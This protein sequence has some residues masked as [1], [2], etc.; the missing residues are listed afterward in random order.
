M[1]SWHTIFDHYFCV[2]SKTLSEEQREKLFETINSATDLLGWKVEI[3]SPND[4][5]NAM[6]QRLAASFM[7]STPDLKPTLA[8]T[9]E[10]SRGSS[11]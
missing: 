9:S 5:S 1:Y 3:L 4:I 2:D 10:D 7:V 6:L 11:H 8:T